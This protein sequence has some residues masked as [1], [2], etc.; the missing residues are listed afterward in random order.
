MQRNTKQHNFFFIYKIS[1]FVSL[2]LLSRHLL[3]KYASNIFTKRYRSILSLVC[4]R[5]TSQISEF[6]F[7]NKYKALLV[8]KGYKQKYGV[9]YKEVFAL[10]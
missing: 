9:D 2:S 7:N 8:A 3:H 10:V 6:Y 1:A 5:F 4:V